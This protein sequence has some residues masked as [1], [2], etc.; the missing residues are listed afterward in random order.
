MVRWLAVHQT[1]GVD[2]QSGREAQRTDRCLMGDD[3]KYAVIWPETE[4]RLSQR[5][6]LN[7]RGVF[8]QHH[9]HHQISW[10]HNRVAG[11]CILCL[12]CISHTVCLAQSLRGLVKIYWTP[13][14]EILLP[15][16]ISW[17][18]LDSLKRKYFYTRNAVRKVKDN[19]SLC[20]FYSFVHLDTSLLILTSRS[21]QNH[22]LA[23][24]LLALGDLVLH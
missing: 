22:D 13:G 4:A 24:K 5:A 8:H 14:N 17:I 15:R 18:V 2:H 9:H 10:R 20:V 21:A 6:S 1:P 11:R 12:F 3:T 23:T 19:G 16:R 7:D